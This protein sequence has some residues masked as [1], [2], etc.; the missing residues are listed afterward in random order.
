MTTSPDWRMT[1][2]FW[3]AGLTAAAV[4]AVGAVVA[5][6]GAVVGAAGAVVAFAGAAVGAAG[7][8]VG[9]GG[10][11]GAEVGVAGEAQAVSTIDRTTKRETNTKAFFMAFS[12]RINV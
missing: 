4:V 6:A 5:F 12:L 8:E 2:G 1:T 7:A 3:S 11:V 10:L 9:A